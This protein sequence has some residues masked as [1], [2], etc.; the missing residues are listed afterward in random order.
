MRRK[1]VHSS[2]D[3]L[4]SFVRRNGTHEIV[5]ILNF[6]PDSSVFSSLQLS[7]NFINV[8]TNEIVQY[9]ESNELHLDGWKFLVLEK[10]NVSITEFL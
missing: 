6:S 2:N 3:N 8:F 4:F 10:I 7:G 5:V 1:M 9:D